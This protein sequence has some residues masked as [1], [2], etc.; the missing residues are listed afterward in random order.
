MIEPNRLRMPH[1]KSLIRNLGLR[2]DVDATN[3]QGPFKVDG[4]S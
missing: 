3:F 1:S 2:L 4:G